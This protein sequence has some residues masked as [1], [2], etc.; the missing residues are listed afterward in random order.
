MST[1]STRTT[2]WHDVRAVE[3]EA[4]RRAF[5]L[6]ARGPLG[7]PNPQVGAVLLDRDG[8]TIGEGWHD[9][10]G[11][12][13]AEI[14]A[15][16]AARA[17]GHDVRGAT[18]VVTLEPCNHTGRTGPCAAALLAAG[19]GRLV[20]S[21]ADP[22]PVAAGG[23]ERRAGAGVEVVGGVLVEEGREVLR[24]WLPSVT[25]GRPFV[26][27]KMV[28]TLDGRVAAADRTSRWI[29]SEQS[30]RH[31]HD[32][33]A[34]VDAIA[35]GTGT[36]LTDDPTL[37]ARDADGA[38][39]AHQPTRVVVGLRDVPA[40]AALHGPG[41]PFVQFRTHDPAQVLDALTT[42]GLR[43]LLVE[44]GPTLS[45]AFLRA[46]LVDEVHAYVAPV[47]LGAGPSAVGD[48]GIGT[49]ADALRL[50]VVRT[51]RLGPD[52]LVVATRSEN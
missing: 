50:S 48:L 52:L 14:V 39:A 16:Q 4:L 12:L 47:L 21:V 28:V 38:L 32:I 22:N 19:V 17:A 51:V 29:S 45:A 34:Q 24:L 3:V 25:E 20:Y 15:V 23:A 10:A 41:G 30:R 18:V 37:T 26:T 43:H 6:A 36:A 2:F 44:G 46:H 27:L 33:R 9:G 40:D 5:L 1:T 7:G 11:T 31:S 13:H 8:R 42:R 35:V 49:I